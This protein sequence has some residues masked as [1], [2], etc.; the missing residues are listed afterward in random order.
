MT[1]APE[2]H[3]SSPDGANLVPSASYALHCPFVPQEMCDYWT[4][5]EARVLF[6]PQ[7]EENT[8]QSIREQI[9]I[10]MAAKA[11]E[12]AYLTVITGSPEFD[13]N[14][15]SNYQKHCARQKCQLLCKALNLALDNMNG[16]SWDKCCQMAVK[17][18]IRMCI[19]MPK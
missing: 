11:S 14:T 3:V 12:T 4:Y 16:W 10:L 9:A 6:Q 7:S 5:T 17:T 2:T 19:N 8:W 15:L 18:G 13:D 1:Q